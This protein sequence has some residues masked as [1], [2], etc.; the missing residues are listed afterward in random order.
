MLTVGD[1]FPEFELTACVSLEKGKEF[2]TIDHKTY[3]GK[4]KVIFAWPLDFTFVCPTEIAAFGKLNDEFADR[5]A[6]VLGFSLDSEYVHH[7]WRK[8]HA[9]LR[10]LP[11][12]MMSDIKRE[13]SAELGILGEDGLP[14][15]AVFVVD[16]NNEIQFSMV[17]AGSVGRNPKE[18]LRVLDALQTDELCPCNWTKGETTLD[19]VALLSGE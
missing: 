11:F 8:D 14:M 6:Q 9:D 7:A 1:K 4:W 16:P 15:R 12:P 3:E 13:L 2:E 10:D 18:V 17:T 19:P 5:D